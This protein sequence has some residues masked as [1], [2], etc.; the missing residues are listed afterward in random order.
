MRPEFAT[1]D[2][3]ARP[4]RTGVSRAQGP[5]VAE[6]LPPLDPRFPNGQQDRAK[7]DLIRPLLGDPLTHEP[8][9]CGDPLDDRGDGQLDSDFRQYPVRGCVPFLGLSP[10]DLLKV[11][12]RRAYAAWREVQA[13]GESSYLQDGPIGNFSH[14]GW[15]PAVETG[16]VLARIFRGQDRPWV[17]DVGCGLLAEPA[18]QSAAAGTGTR[19][20]GLDPLLGHDERRAPFVVGFGD[21]LPFR[22]DAL[23]GVC[24]ISSLDHAI[25]PYRAVC[26]AWRVLRPGGALVI[27]ETMRPA[28]RD[29]WKWYFRSCLGPT[30]FNR[31]HNFAFRPQSLRRLVR[32]ARFVALET[33]VTSD[34]REI[35]LVARKP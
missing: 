26:D 34:P 4:L 2:V 33:H 1:S 18:Y 14:A 6:R 35:C 31:F 23:D 20:I 19:F 29:Y 16:V 12:G 9:R 28:N 11:H 27:E 5:K 7:F 15:A 13:E 17:L 22:R 3:S 32:R 24:F 25:N 30:R 10:H 21:H 8:L